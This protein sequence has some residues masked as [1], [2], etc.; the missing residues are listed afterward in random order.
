MR[1]SQR[2]E[3]EGDKA[4]T[5]KKKWKNKKIKRFLWVFCWHASILA[6]WQPSGQKRALNFPVPSYSQLQACRL[7]RLTTEPPLQS[8]HLI[9]QGKYKTQ[10]RKRE[11]VIQSKES[12]VKDTLGV[13]DL[14]W[15]R[16]FVAVGEERVYLA[17]TSALQSI[18]KLSH[19]RNRRQELK[20]RPRQNGAS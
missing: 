6:C 18:I 10:T 7:W 17:D 4:W 20:Q 5:V 13:L 15:V 19:S 8:S 3:R 2:L 9:L 1:N 16:A 11:V 12:H 14:C